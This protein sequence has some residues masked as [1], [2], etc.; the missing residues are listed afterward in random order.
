MR[1]L[2]LLTL[3]LTAGISASSA[4]QAQWD[5]IRY[6]TYMCQYFIIN[7]DPPP[8]LLKKTGYIDGIGHRVGRPCQTHGA[9]WFSP[10]KK[11]TVVCV[12]P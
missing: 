8:W 12:R 7:S 1:K 6:C 2:L 5:P 10:I 4:A 3:T 11:G 9:Q